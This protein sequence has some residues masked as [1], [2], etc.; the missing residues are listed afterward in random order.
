MSDHRKES[1]MPDGDKK[2]APR[3][4]SEDAAL[5]PGRQIGSFKIEKELGR[6]GMG[7]VYL[8][9]DTGLDRLVAIKT[10]AGELASNTGA[11]SRLQREARCLASLNHPNVAIIYE[12]IEYAQRS[13]YLVLEY[14]PGQTLTERIAEGTLGLEEALKIGLQIAG[15]LSAAHGSAVAHGDLKP[16]NIKITPEGNVKVLDFGLARVVGIEASEEDSSAGRVGRMA[17]TPPYMSPEQL[18][19]EATDHRTDIWSYGCLLY[20]ML[21]GVRAF[22]GDS[23]AEVL[24]SVLIAEP[25]LEKLPPKVPQAVRRIIAKCV[26]KNLEKRYQ[27]AGELLQD[28]T[29]CLSALTGPAEDLKAL[30]RFV[31][32]PYVAVSLTLLLLGFCTIGLWLSHRAV[33]TRW[34]RNKALPEI[35]RLIEQDKYFEAFV[36]AREAEKYIPKD[37]MLLGFWPRISRDCSITTTPGG[38]E[39]FLSEYLAVDASWR[40]LGRSPLERARVPCGICRWR[41]EKEGFETVETVMVNLPSSQW[42]RPD[43]TPAREINFALREEGSLPPSMVWIPPSQL[44]LRLSM[45]HSFESIAAPAYMI[46]KYEVTNKQFE[47]F[48]EADGYQNR[49]YWKNLRFEGSCGPVPRRYRAT[50]AIDLGGGDLSRGLR[51]LPGLGSKL[52]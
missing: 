14:V 12:E 9:R 35:A 38:A 46:D 23:T 15:A 5:G 50:R 10:L 49:A 37:P 16:S 21:S 30:S 29:D 31:K 42:G 36:L 17:G 28:L 6:G 4:P 33:K 43:T 26:E 1:N 45:L 41:I 51:R 32:R 3:S 20:E 13:A 22:A 40:R 11:I 19:G 47:K 39:I 2:A 24:T 7:A 18:R 34:A 48:I 52:V 8:A 27:S 44:K 25:D